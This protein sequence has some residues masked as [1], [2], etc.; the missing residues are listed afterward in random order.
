[1]FDLFYSPIN[2]NDH[3]EVI[4]WILVNLEKC[5]DNFWLDFICHLFF[6]DPDQEGGVWTLIWMMMIKA[7]LAHGLLI[8][9]IMIHNMINCKVWS[10]HDGYIGFN[11]PIMMWRLT[12]TKILIKASLSNKDYQRW[13][14]A[15]IL[16]TVAWHP[17]CYKLKPL[18]G[19]QVVLRFLYS[20]CEKGG[21]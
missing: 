17:R 19:I 10:G 14:A 12:K 2:P 11:T 4:H 1:M 15:V 21:A 7:H 20:W 16:I 18:R 6:Y 5:L 13:L 8:S 9:T 3:M